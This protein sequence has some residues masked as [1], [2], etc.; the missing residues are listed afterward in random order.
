MTNF[1]QESKN[2]AIFPAEKKRFDKII[3]ERSELY[4]E[5]CLIKLAGED[6]KEAARIKCEI[7]KIDR[8]IKANGIL[9]GVNNPND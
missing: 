9:T 6:K 8:Q 5:L 2:I 4:R 7:E 1:Q 3:V